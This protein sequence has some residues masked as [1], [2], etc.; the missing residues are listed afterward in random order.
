MKNE[1]ERSWLTKPG[2][3]SMPLGWPSDSHQLTEVRVLAD[4]HQLTARTRA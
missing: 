1:S 2:A 4:S 3:F